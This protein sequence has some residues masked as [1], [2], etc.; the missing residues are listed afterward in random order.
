M[1]EQNSKQNEP[2][3][4]KKRIKNEENKSEKI[5]EDFYKMLEDPRFSL[6]ECYHAAILKGNYDNKL[7]SLKQMD[8]TEDKFSKNI[9]LND[10][11]NNDGTFNIYKTKRPLNCKVGEQLNNLSKKA[12]HEGIAIG[13]EKNILF[14]DYGVK[15]NHLAVRFWDS[16][17]NKD[18]WSVVEKVGVSNASDK[19]IMD[20]F[21]GEKSEN[22]INPNNYNLLLHNCQDYSKEIINQL[23]KIQK[24]P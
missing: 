21:F 15:D 12:H 3:D 8:E 11:R 5:Q 24:N 16:K 20:I 6:E 1:G 22:W 19:E 2:Y 4:R 23:I 10:Y 18:K 9:N 17:E 13:N 14:S 7:N